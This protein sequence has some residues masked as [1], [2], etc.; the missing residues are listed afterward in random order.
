MTKNIK[1]E[2]RTR[3]Q[4][5]LDAYGCKPER[6]PSQH[7]PVLEAMLSR[8]PEAQRAVQDAQALDGLLNQQLRSVTREDANG[9]AALLDRIMQQVVQEAGQHHQGH[10]N[11]KEHTSAEIVNLRAH[12]TAQQSLAAN[13]RPLNRQAANIWRQL[14]AIA[15][16]AASL[17]LG[18]YV[19]GT[20][21]LQTAVDGLNEIAGVSSPTFDTDAATIFN[22]GGS[23][24]LAAE[25]LI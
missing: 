23:D 25:D 7:R 16:L 9:E 11:P 21:Q 3:L 20:G 17:V 19:G 1:Q 15:A 6:W 2:M 14:P 12:R 4:E 10:S 13:A 5:V 8:D 18:I 22:I 24:G